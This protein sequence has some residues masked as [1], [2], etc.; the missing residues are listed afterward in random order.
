MTTVTILSDT[1]CELGEGPSF[2][3]DRNCLYWFDIVGKR[4]LERGS[5]GV[6]LIHDL[7]FMAS[8]LARV[9]A[10]THLVCA[11]NGLYLRD[12]ETG[13]LTLHRALEAE[14][15]VTRSNDARTH[16]SGAFWIGTMGKAAQKGA[17]SIWWY[18]DGE[19][20]RLYDGITIPNAICFSPDGATG[21]FTDTVTA[22]LMRVALDPATGLPRGTPEMFFD[23]SGGDGGLDGAVCDAEGCIWNTRWGASALDR[24]SPQGE[25]VLS[26][27]IPASQPSCPAFFGTDLA[28]IAVTSAWQGMDSAARA[29]DPLAGQT[30]LVDLDVKGRADPPVLL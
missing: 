26:V 23:H 10:R 7:P 30:F 13:D 9:D 25:R 8:A 2:D 15:R 28:R 14:N 6:T 27:S 19:L 1:V 12:A 24:Y 3:P 4:L 21:Y 16:P 18:R 5:D 11:E 29:A 17:G 20:K 22:R